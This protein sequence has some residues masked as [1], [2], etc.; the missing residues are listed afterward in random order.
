DALEALAGQLP[1]GTR[2]YV[3]ADRLLGV[4]SLPTISVWSNGRLLWWRAGGD[5]ITWS[6]ADTPGAARRLAEL[7]ALQASH[8]PAL[9]D[10]G[11]RDRA[12]LYR[13]R[14]RYT[15]RR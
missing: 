6:A 2:S 8:T 7:A 13:S 1:D 3:C 15:S 9:H 10:P 11:D 5:E 12:E 14:F 4:L